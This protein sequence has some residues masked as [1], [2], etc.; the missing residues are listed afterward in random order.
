[1][2]RRAARVL[3][4]LTLLAVLGAL[5]ITLASTDRPTPAEL[6]RA[7]R[8]A[9]ATLQ[10]LE[11]D[12]ARCRESAPASEP[13]VDCASFT[14]DPPPA[15]AFLPRPTFTAGALADLLG[16]VAGLAAFGGFLVGATVG[17]ADW[18]ARSM[19]LLLAWEPRRTRVFGM[20]LGVLVVG[21]LAVATAALAI[22]ATGGALIV[23]QQGGWGGVG[24][25]GLAGPAARGLVLVPLAAAAAYG[26][27]MLARNTGFALGVA[28]GYV[29][30]VE[31]VA[32]NT[33]AWGS[34]WLVQTNAFVVLEGSPTRWVVGARPGG[35]AI[36]V[37]IT[38][39]RALLTLLVWVGVIAALALVAFR[40]RDVAS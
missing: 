22:A 23:T 6:A 39:G 21:A 2:S 26:L 11:R 34:Q 25:G 5:G 8:Q 29:L 19:G 15:S 10:Q 33:W 14:A 9:A 20:R 24:L 17:G 4:V 36:L 18:G 32:Q 37:T 28:A 16:F 30:V 40:R 1:V 7:E 3:A 27:A 38:P 31:T 35:E 13:A 12:E